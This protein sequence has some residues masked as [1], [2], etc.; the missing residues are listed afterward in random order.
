MFCYSGD[1]VRRA[2]SLNFVC[3]KTETLTQSTF[4]ICTVLSAQCAQVRPAQI[5]PNCKNSGKRL[6]R[7]DDRSFCLCTNTSTSAHTHTHNH[8]NENTQLSGNVYGRCA[9]CG[10]CIKRFLVLQRTCRCYWCFVSFHSFHFF[11]FFLVVPFQYLHSLSFD[12]FTCKH[13]VIRFTRFTTSYSNIPFHT[14][15]F[16]FVVC[17]GAN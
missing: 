3:M 7:T 15:L 10:C 11:C 14:V 17:A 12:R 5:Q 8:R 9:G 6:T 2:G 13:C 16:V 4:F 1:F